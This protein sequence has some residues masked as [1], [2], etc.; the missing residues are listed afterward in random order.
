MFMKL[1]NSANLLYTKASKTSHLFKE[2]RTLSK[3]Q[4]GTLK[5]LLILYQ[6]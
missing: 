3:F 2:N 1:Y 4:I 5:G 6:C